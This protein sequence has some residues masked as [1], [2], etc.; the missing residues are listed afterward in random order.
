M[1]D[2]HTRSN[3]E[4]KGFQILLP[5]MSQAEQLCTLI[6]IPQFDGGIK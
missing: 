1:L 2:I 6:N 4:M 5:V 3:D